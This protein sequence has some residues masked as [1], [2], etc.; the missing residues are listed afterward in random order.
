MSAKFA[1]FFISC[2]LTLPLSAADRTCVA[3][4]GHM[5]K[6]ISGIRVAIASATAVEHPGEC[7]A[8]VLF[9]T[10]TAVYEAYGAEAAIHPVSGKDVDGDGSPDAVLETVSA[11]A[12]HYA[13]VSLSQ[14]PGLVRELV[15]SVPLNFEDLDGD[16]RI[17]IWARDYAFLDFDGLPAAVSP[18]P[19]VVFRLKGATLTHVSQAFWSEYEKEIAEARGLISQDT[20][21]DFLAVPVQG[22]DKKPKELGPEEQRRVT[23]LKGIVLEIILAYL[24]GGRGQEAWKALDDMWPATDKPRM[25]QMIL[26][27]RTS[28]ILSEINRQHK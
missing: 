8:A 25:R 22:D 11:G 15:V 14:S 3:G 10:G 27:A 6:E 9:P 24:Y 17:E 26:K 7:H 19:R 28:G 5:E 2:L 12:F 20:L 21:D 13:V 16:G 18:A 4:R 23:E 1:T